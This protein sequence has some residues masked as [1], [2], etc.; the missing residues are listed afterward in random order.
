M[1]GWALTRTSSCDCLAAAVMG[2]WAASQLRNVCEL[3][4]GP[5]WRDGRCLVAIPSPHE[6]LPRHVG[7]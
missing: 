6:Q 7:G 3:S 5:Q 1:T 4:F 2:W